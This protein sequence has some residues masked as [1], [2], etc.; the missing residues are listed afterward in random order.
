MM[1]IFEGQHDKNIFKAIFLV[2]PPGSG[3]NFIAH[4]LN[5]E[6]QGLKQVDIDDVLM[7]MRY[8]TKKD[9]TYDQAYQIVTKRQSLYMKMYLG[10]VINCTGRNSSQIL[11][12][13]K[14]LENFGYN[15]FMV[16]V[17]V[18]KKTALNRISTRPS[19]STNVSDKGRIVD[20][21]YFE[22]AYNQTI[23]NLD[24]YQ[25]IFQNNFSMIIN[26]NDLSS[27]DQQL[28]ITNRKIKSFLLTPTKSELELRRRN[29]I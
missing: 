20:V 3:K 24:I 19:L 26:R 1:N 7:R 25:D 28:K 27:L 13:K 4:K 22:I 23:K 29:R 2:G 9:I 5:L 10:L 8:L 16:F 11:L 12:L 18:D 14:Q 21:D 15:T 6:A 17:N